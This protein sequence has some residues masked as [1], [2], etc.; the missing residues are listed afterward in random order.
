MLVIG[1]DIDRCLMQD[2]QL[3]PILPSIGCAFVSTDLIT[4]MAYQTAKLELIKSNASATLLSKRRSSEIQAQ[5]SIITLWFINK[6][7]SIFLIREPIISA[8]ISI[9]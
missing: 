2:I 9:K 6:P 8:S 1:F 7:F 4:H 3:L 5:F